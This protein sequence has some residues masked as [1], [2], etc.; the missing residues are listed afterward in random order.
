MMRKTRFLIG[1]AILLGLAVVGPGC[2]KPLFPE[3]APRSPYE[4][5]MVLRGQE[6]PTKTENAFGFEIPDIRNRLKPL[7]SP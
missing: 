4:R 5:Y 3:A 1:G 7:G 2:E 6:R